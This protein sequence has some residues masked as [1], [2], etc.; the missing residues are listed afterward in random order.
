MS[1]NAFSTCSDCGAH[2]RFYQNK[3]S[4]WIPF[5]VEDIDSDFDPH[6]ADSHWKTCTREKLIEPFSYESRRR[7]GYL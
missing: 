1:G 7:A 2:I 3:R 4:T 6:T 5:N